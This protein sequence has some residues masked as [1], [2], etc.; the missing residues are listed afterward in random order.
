MS[1]VEPGRD[2]AVGVPLIIA[3]QLGLQ[4]A[5][6]RVHAKAHLYI[7][8]GADSLD[9]IDLVMSIE[10]EFDL[11]VPDEAADRWKTV[12]DVAA[13]VTAALAARGGR[14]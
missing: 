13:W 3:D 6:E 7:D 10:E 11:E 1:A 2:P 5:T 9:L 14:Q 12:G 8:L 4:D